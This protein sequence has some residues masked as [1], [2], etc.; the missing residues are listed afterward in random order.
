MGSKIFNF[1][2]FFNNRDVKT[3]LDGSSILL[4]ERK[5]FPFVDKDHNH[6]ITSNLNIIT[7]NKLCKR[8]SNSPKYQENGTGEYEK[9]I[10][11]I[12]SC[13]QSWCN[14]YGVTTSS[15]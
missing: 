10:T 12:E 14:K 9:T 7:N 6:I 15:F 1:N 11:G 3:F 5:C 4:G 13:I 2:K 8:F